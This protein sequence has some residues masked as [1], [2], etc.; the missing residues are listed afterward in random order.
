VKKLISSYVHY[1]HWANVTLTRWLKTFDNELLHKETRSSFHS[2]DLTLQH[3]KNAQNFWLSIITE[4]SRPDETIKINV[5]DQVIQ[6]L[7]TGSQRMI[8]TFTNYTEEELQQL[9]QSDNMKRSRYE[10]I[11]HVINH[12][13]YHRGQIVTMARGF[14]ITNNIPETEY[15]AFLWGMEKS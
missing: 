2:I 11:L 13:S 14:G 5:I 9:V 15:E 3:M 10:F 12:N 6:E 4:V 1:N 7:L 8:D